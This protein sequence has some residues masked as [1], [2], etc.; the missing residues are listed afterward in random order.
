[1][2][3]SQC[4][5]RIPLSHQP[6]KVLAVYLGFGAATCAAPFLFSSPASWVIGAS[7]GFLALVALG[8]VSTEMTDASASVFSRF[9]RQGGACGHICKIRP[10]S[11]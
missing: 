9:Q 10:W 8:G 2:T 7:T 11:W 6:G 3:C 5:A 4:S 1:M